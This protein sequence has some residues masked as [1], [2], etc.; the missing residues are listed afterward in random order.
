MVA[1]RNDIGSIE[2]PV[3]LHIERILGKYSAKKVLI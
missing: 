1:I 3:Q 2:L